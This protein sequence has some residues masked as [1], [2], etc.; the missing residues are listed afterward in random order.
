MVGDIQK[1]TD[2]LKEL[3]YIQKKL[4]TIIAEY[5]DT[6]DTRKLVEKIDNDEKLLT[7]IKQHLIDIIRYD[8][9]SLK[10]YINLF[11][12][13]TITIHISKLLK[14]TLDAVTIKKEMLSKEITKKFIEKGNTILA[15]VI[16]DIN[17]WTWN[18]SPTTPCET[19]TSYNTKSLYKAAVDFATDYL[20]SSYNTR[21]EDLEILKI[22]PNE[23]YN[24]FDEKYHEWLEKI[25]AKLCKEDDENE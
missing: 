15:K 4:A 19:Y 7:A 13:F 18:I 2:R 16:E 8:I 23:I 20:Y 3:K 17:Y 10:D 14:D 5:E 22:M 24:K 1:L 21:L 11:D 9:Y 6:Y 12:N 25:I